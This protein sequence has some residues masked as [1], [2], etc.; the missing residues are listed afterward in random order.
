MY[1]NINAHT[2]TRTNTHTHI[3]I[4]YPYEL[5]YIYIYLQHYTALFSGCNIDGGLLHHCVG[6]VGQ[7]GSGKFQWPMRKRH[8]QIDICSSIYIYM[9]KL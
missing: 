7:H 3:Y 5:L 4:L 8:L 6:H 9:G 1:I 2:H